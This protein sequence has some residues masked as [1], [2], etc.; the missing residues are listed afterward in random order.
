MRAVGQG[1]RPCEVWACGK[2]EGRRLARRV[3][4]GVPGS[5]QHTT[6]A[7]RRAPPGAPRP[8]PHLGASA[9]P[10]ASPPMRGSGRT[11]AASKI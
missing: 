6:R 4:C 10:A 7:L 11:L 2:R 5:A 9:N 1:R 8:V 3:V